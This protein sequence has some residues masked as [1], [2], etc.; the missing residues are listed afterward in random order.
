MILWSL[1]LAGEVF[2]N[3]LYHMHL[4]YFHVYGNKYKSSPI[5][6]KEKKENG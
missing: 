6:K 2:S 4:F 1:R 5:L 3:V